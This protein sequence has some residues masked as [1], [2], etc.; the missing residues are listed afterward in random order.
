MNYIFDL[1][2]RGGWRPYRSKCYKL[3]T[4]PKTWLQAVGLCKRLGGDL[5]SIPD[6][7][8]NDFLNNWAKEKLGQYYLHFVGGY[9]EVENRWA[10]IDRTNW[11]FTKWNVGE[12]NNFR[13]A[14]NC[15]SVNQQG[16][17]NDHSCNTAPA[18]YF[19]AV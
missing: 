14:E 6:N 13:G 16:L 11:Q 7:G 12:P 2:C 10:W 9:E 4:G 19:C 3:F 18:P 17:W 8:V 1:G 15:L 5:P